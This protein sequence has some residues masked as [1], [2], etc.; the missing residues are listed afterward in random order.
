VGSLRLGSYSASIL[1]CS[2]WSASPRGVLQLRKSN[3][4]I[5]SGG[6][7]P[8]PVS[9]CRPY[10]LTI[11]IPRSIRMKPCS[12]SLPSRSNTTSLLAPV[13]RQFHFATDAAVAN[14]RL[15][16]L[17]QSFP[18]KGKRR[19]TQPRRGASEIVVRQSCVSRE[20]PLTHP[21]NLGPSTGQARHIAVRGEC[22]LC[23][24]LTLARHWRTTRAG[25]Y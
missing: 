13:A 8:S 2:F 18:L 25:C 5:N 3:R 10:P 16:Q 7:E 19:L 15:R 23:G 6:E 1:F 21:L 14:P 24:F 20:L 4:A 12:G 17:R 11:T 9:L 22:R